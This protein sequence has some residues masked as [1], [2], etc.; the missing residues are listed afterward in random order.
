MREKKREDEKENERG[1]E[2]QRKNEREK[3][4]EDFLSSNECILKCCYV[5]YFK[6]DLLFIFHI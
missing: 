3:N 4:L 1:R 5:V 2:W 6:I